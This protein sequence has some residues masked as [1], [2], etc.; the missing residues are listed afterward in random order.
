VTILDAT[1]IDDPVTRDEWLAVQL[2]FAES[3]D[4]ITI[5]ERL[6]ATDKDQRKNC[7]CRPTTLVLGAKA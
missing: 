7:T 3:G 6:C 4:V 1:E 5:H 2:T